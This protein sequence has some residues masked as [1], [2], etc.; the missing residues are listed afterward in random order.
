MLVSVGLPQCST[1]RG[2]SKLETGLCFSLLRQPGK[3]FL[4]FLLSR[5]NW[6]KDLLELPLGLSLLC[7]LKQDTSLSEQG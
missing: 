3:A 1:P 5:H 2:L 7:D 4:K 6:E